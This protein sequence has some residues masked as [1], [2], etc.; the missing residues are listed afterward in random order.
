MGEMTELLIVIMLGVLGGALGSFA[1]ASVWRLR[2]LQLKE[3][4]ADGEKVSKK[5][6]E[7]LLPLLDAPV[8]KDRSR[9]LHCGHTLAWYDLL[10]FISWLVLRGKCRYCHKSIG[11]FE[12]L[13][14]LGVA[15]FFVISYL[16]W[17]YGDFQTPLE[18]I[19]FVIWLG[20]GVLLSI[21]FAYDAK[22]FL[23]PNRIVFPLVAIGVFNVAVVA[24]GSGDVIGTV[25]SAL[26]ASGILSG[27]Y[28]LLY[29]ISKGAWVGFGDVK[30]GLGL[31]LV[32][33]DWKLAAF[34]LFTANLVGCLVVLPGML[35]RKLSRKAHVPFGPM[36]IAGWAIAGLFGPAIITWYLGL[37]I[38]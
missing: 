1:G 13:M 2:A 36:L 14:E 10:P 29:V 30:L 27:L 12:P 4:V 28:L 16:A 6:T 33:I 3:D 9:C 22:W 15:A 35:S 31:A 17:P 38:Y 8:T 25:V 7:R 5:E 21:L 19:R 26:L 24:L 37:I 20:A 32:L 23:L 18:I 11:Y 34:A